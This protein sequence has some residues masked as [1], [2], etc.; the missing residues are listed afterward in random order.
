MS[1]EPF[2]QEITSLDLAGID[3]VIVGGES[4]KT[5]YQIEKD[6]N[7]EDKFTMKKDKVV[8]THALDGNG[9]KIIEKVIRPVKLEWVEKIRQICKEQNVPFFF[10]QWGMKKFNP[11]PKDPTLNKR[12]RYY[13]K[14]GC[15]I[16]GEIYLE[17]PSSS[18]SKPSKIDV[19]GSKYY[20][21]DDFQELKT[22]WELKSYLPLMEKSL[23][24]QLKTDIKKNGLN[25]PILYF[26]T[27]AGD[28]LVIEGH[29]RL[30]A[31]IKQKVKKI[32]TKEIKADF[33]N[34][35]DIKFWMV[36]HQIQRRNLSVLE[37]VKLSFTHKDIIEKKAL[38]NKSK[39]GKKAKINKHYDTNDE[40][41]RI[42][43][44][45]RAT[46]V[47]YGSVIDKASKS[48]L[49]QLDSGNISIYSAYKM[50]KD[51]TPKPINTKEPKHNSPLV[52]DSIEDCEQALETGIIEAIVILKDSDKTSIFNN[53]QL[54]KLGFIIK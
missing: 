1:I 32:S 16:N 21:M 20:I 54:K 17:N 48:V 18:G 51:K 38:E 26:K 43:G 33:Q 49:N 36:Q 41:A 11:N 19:F 7:G 30:E 50:V 34:L 39:A 13:A 53:N 14:G 23:Y 8:F 9:N 44:V 10:K 40:I 6:E 5:T 12:H 52:F 22:I 45:S 29:T 3:W 27:P 25:D 15:M 24:K 28:K 47:R 42:S 2:I 46:V 35:D 31:C 4:G 37:K